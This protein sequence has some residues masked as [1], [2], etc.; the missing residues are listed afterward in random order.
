M[1]LMTSE[2]FEAKF[3]NADLG[4]R[5]RPNEM[6]MNHS[7]ILKILPSAAC[8]DCLRGTSSTLPK[9]IFI[10]YN[11]LQIFSSNIFRR[12]EGV[13]EKKILHFKMKLF[14][15]TKKIFFGKSR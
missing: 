14:L 2:V 3:Q 5:Q 6:M 8:V 9:N 13:L 11:F 15:I 12:Y 7:L 10:N 1:V 4:R